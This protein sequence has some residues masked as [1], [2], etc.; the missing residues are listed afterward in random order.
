MRY[1]LVALL[2]AG[3]EEIPPV[4]SGRPSDNEAVSVSLLFT[5]D[6]CKVYRFFDLGRDR[7]FVKCET[8]SGRT[9]TSE[10]CGKNCTRPIEIPTEV[11]K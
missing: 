1:V 9:L 6:G 11:V 10:G 8:G 7:Y 5:Y 4:S 3:C 2:L